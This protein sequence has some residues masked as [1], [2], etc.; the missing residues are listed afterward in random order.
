MIS[1]KVSLEC[2]SRTEDENFS[3]NPV[4]AE[5]A[6]GHTML[7]MKVFSVKVKIVGS[8]PCAKKS[9]CPNKESSLNA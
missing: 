6:V 8:A 5:V 1:S 2:C 9:I 7:P 4:E 3:R